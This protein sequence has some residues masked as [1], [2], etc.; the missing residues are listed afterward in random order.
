[1]RNANSTILLQRPEEAIKKLLQQCQNEDKAST[2]AQCCCVLGAKFLEMC[3][4]TIRHMFERKTITCVSNLEFPDVTTHAIFTTTSVNNLRNRNEPTLTFVVSGQ[5]YELIA[6]GSKDAEPKSQPRWLVR[7]GENFQRFWIIEKHSK[8]ARKT[9]GNPT[10]VIQS[11]FH[12]Y[13]T[14]AIFEKTRNVDLADLKWQVLSTLTGQ[15]VFICQKHDLP[16]TRDFRKSTFRCRCGLCSFL[17][18]PYFQCHSCTCKRH[19]KEGLKENNT[20]VLINAAPC[21]NEEIMELSSESDSSVSTNPRSGPKRFCNMPFVESTDPEAAAETADFV[22]ISNS[23]VGDELLPAKND[24]EYIDENFKFMSKLKPCQD[25]K[26]LSVQ[27]SRK[28]ENFKLPL[29]ILLNS[30][31]NLLYRR[32]GNPISLTLKETFRGKYRRNLNF[33]NFVASG[34][35]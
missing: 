15:G 32:K 9:D 19:F 11:A 10:E 24:D 18:C 3:C 25:G 5:E 16:L 6:L 12:G 8:F 14:I 31:C 29:H 27:R 21:P 28:E 1:M 4:D 23:S 22:T 13:W 20:R 26:V 30:Q 34:S 2:I 33:L 35:T 17:R 7:H